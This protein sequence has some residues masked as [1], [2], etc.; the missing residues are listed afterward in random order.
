MTWLLSIYD[1][2]EIYL[3]CSELWTTNT[4][5]KWPPSI[6]T[7]FEQKIPSAISKKKK[8][9]KVAK[10]SNH[11]SLLTLSPSSQLIQPKLLKLLDLTTSLSENPKDPFLLTGVINTCISHARNQNG[12]MFKIHTNSFTNNSN[13][14]LYDYNIFMKNSYLCKY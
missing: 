7:V 5:A 4:I 3:I 10:F 11:L 6:F 1:Y 12:E 14:S 9:K 13:K 8:K 2:S